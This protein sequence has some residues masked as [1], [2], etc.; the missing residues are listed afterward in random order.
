MILEEYKE[1]PTQ[2]P[3]DTEEC[4]FMQRGTSQV[5]FSMV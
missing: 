4:G 1:Y 3:C 2:N 5:N